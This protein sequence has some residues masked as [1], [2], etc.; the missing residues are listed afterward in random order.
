MSIYTD[1]L[2]I[3]QGTAGDPLGQTSAIG[4]LIGTFGQAGARG[5]EGGTGGGGTTGSG[6]SG[7]ANPAPATPQLDPN[8]AAALAMEVEEPL[9]VEVQGL[10]TPHPHP[11]PQHHNLTRTL[12]QRW[13]CLLKVEGE[14]HL[15]HLQHQ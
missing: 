9:V 5:D 8:L 2:G 6:G 1:M 7:S 15:P 13:Q 4:N 14:T 10:L 12:Q 3:T 11:H